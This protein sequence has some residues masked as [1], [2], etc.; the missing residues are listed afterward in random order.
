MGDFFPVCFYQILQ[1]SILKKE[2]LIQTIDNQIGSYHASSLL[3]ETRAPTP[4][5]VGRAI[6]VEGLNSILAGLWGIG[7]GVTTLTENVHTAL[8]LTGIV[9]SNN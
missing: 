7:T 2:T 6:G 8:P 3:V 1:F 9:F 4:G 5:I